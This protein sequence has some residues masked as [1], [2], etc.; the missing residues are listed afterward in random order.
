MGGAQALGVTVPLKENHSSLL[1]NDKTKVKNLNETLI[2]WLLLERVYLPFMCLLNF[3]KDPVNHPSNC[4]ANPSFVTQLSTPIRRIRIMEKFCSLLHINSRITIN[5]LHQTTIHLFHSTI[6]PQEET[7]CQGRHERTTLN[8]NSPCR[9]Q[10][11]FHAPTLCLGR[12]ADGM[13]RSCDNT[14]GDYILF[15]ANGRMTN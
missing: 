1:L 9:G 5:H 15:W 13:L 10:F 11:H 3:F 8:L 12:Y 7:H 4:W 14:G 2:K 6:H